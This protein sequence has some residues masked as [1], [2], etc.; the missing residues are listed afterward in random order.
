MVPLHRFER[1]FSSLAG[2]Y[3]LLASLAALFLVY[4]RVA[5]LPNSPS[6]SSLTFRLFSSPIPRW[7]AWLDLLR[8]AAYAFRER[9][10]TTWL[11]FGVFAAVWLACLLW[12]QMERRR[13]DLSFNLEEALWMAWMSLAVFSVSV[14]YGL[15][16][17]GVFSQRLR[18]LVT[19]SDVV[20]LAFILALPVIAWFRLHR[21]HLQFLDDSSEFFDDSAEPALQ[22]RNSGFLGLDSVGT[23]VRLA[24]SLSPREVSPEV[25]PV[26]TLATVQMF[27]ERP[28]E[29]ASGAA[30][31]PIE[32]AESPVIAKLLESAPSLATVTPISAAAEKLA[33]KGID[34]FRG[35]LSTM[36]SSWQKIET[37][38]R[39][40]D[41]WFEQRRQ[42]AIA[43]LDAHPGMRGST[44]AQN[45]FNDFP[46]DKLSAVDAEWA[47]IRRSTLEISR[48]FGDVPASDRNR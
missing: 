35:H 3:A 25:R 7:R 43:H 44:L 6:L 2:C 16:T 8:E 20:A 1:G 22:R 46:N 15:G 11:F 47:E 39:E 31:R 42:Q 19:A 9:M 21:Q 48:W 38:R 23:D 34:S 45:L 27:H 4:A 30:D 14:F 33:P 17:N 12:M 5:L 32:S 41:D 26:K 18:Q 37:I 24:E 10:H 29:N 13:R 28:A 40:I 36:N